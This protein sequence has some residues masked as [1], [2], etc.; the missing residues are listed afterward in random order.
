MDLEIERLL[1]KLEEEIRIGK[2]T[3]FSGGRTSIDDI[4]CLSIIGQIRSAL[5]TAITEA[6]VVLQDSNNIIEQANLRANDIVTK[7]QRDANAF[8]KQ[9]NR[10]G[11]ARSGQDS[12]NGAP[13]SG[14]DK[15][16][17]LRQHLRPVQQR[18]KRAQALS[19]TGRGQQT[20][21]VRRD[22]YA[23]TLKK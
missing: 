3:V 1:D 15:K 22:E 13:G 19:R 21:T 14:C 17:K 6:R 11:S 12:R 4:K 8:R 16:R 10:P 7:A 18:G 5:P 9:H 23:K 20:G 2:K